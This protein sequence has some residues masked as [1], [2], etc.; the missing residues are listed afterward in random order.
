VLEVRREVHLEVFVIDFS[1]LLKGDVGEI[2]V[3]F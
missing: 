3:V 1:I 2:L